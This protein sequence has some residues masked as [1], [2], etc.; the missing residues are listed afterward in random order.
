MASPITWADVVNVRYM[1]TNYDA[2]PESFGYIVAPGG[3][4]TFET[5]FRASGSA[6]TIFDAIRNEV[7]V[8]KQIGDGRV[9]AGIW[10]YLCVGTWGTGTE[11]FASDIIIDAVTQAIS[12]RVIVTGSMFCDCAIRWPALF[13]Y[14]AANA[15]GP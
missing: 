9:F 15:V 8:S 10:N 11:E 4:Q 12:G 5:T 2:S 6:L 13:S 7:E 3:R 14:T 1:S